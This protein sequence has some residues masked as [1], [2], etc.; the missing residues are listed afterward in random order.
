MTILSKKVSGE[1]YMKAETYLQRQTQVQPG[2][3]FNHVIINGGADDGL[4][5]DALLQLAD[6][7]ISV[8]HI[9]VHE[10]D[11]KTRRLSAKVSY[12]DKSV[13]ARVLSAKYLNYFLERLETADSDSNNDREIAVSSELARQIEA[14]IDKT[15]DISNCTEA[16]IMQYGKPELIVV[17]EA[18]LRRLFARLGIAEY[19]VSYNTILKGFVFSLGEPYKIRKLISLVAAVV[20]KCDTGKSLAD[21]FLSIAAEMIRNR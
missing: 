2:L 9:S 4:H 15:F 18:E 10:L 8:L 11:A 13:N 20:R 6:N 12:T 14:E 17:A 7:K 16:D 19:D 3:Y 5:L 21:S 1:I